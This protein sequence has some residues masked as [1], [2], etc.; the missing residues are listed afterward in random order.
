M[1]DSD[2]CST[3]FL[4]LS[5][6][7]DCCQLSQSSICTKVRYRVRKR[8]YP[9]LNI[10]MLWF[11]SHQIF[12]RLEHRLIDRHRQ[13]GKTEVTA[14]PIKTPH[15]RKSDLQLHVRVQY[16]YARIFARVPGPKQPLRTKV[17]LMRAPAIVT[18]FSALQA[19]DRRR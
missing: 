7:S 17:H 5:I 8:T 10:S 6:R 9:K 4:G 16:W 15:R 1:A 11:I 19:F 14:L 2:F 13:F 3:S 12:R 18:M